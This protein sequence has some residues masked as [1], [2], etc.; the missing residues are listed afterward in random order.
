[1][2]ASVRGL[3]AV[4]YAGRL[5]V[6]PGTY[7]PG[8]TTPG[9][10]RVVHDRQGNGWHGVEFYAVGRTGAYFPAVLLSADDARRFARLV[11]RA[12]AHLEAAED[13]ARDGEPVV[14]LC[15]CESSA[16]LGLSGLCPNATT[17][18]ASTLCGDCW[19]ADT[20]TTHTYP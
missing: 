17:D 10:P 11:I 13:E 16:H 7:G 19:R 14:A 1:M 2:S 3:P 5:S 4:G 15:L 8:A 6:S 20:G 18:H 12:A 9:V